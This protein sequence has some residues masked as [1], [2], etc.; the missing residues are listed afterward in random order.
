MSLITVTRLTNTLGH[1]P[2]LH[3]LGALQLVTETGLLSPGLWPLPAAE[4][5]EPHH[6]PGQLRQQLPLLDNLALQPLSGLTLL[7]N[8][9]LH[10]GH[11]CCL[12]SHL[13]QLLPEL[14]D[15]DEELPGDLVEGG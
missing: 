1:S 9:M 8:T 12:C 13:E 11:N 14:S 10:R 15:G 4:Y 5:L 2:R 6:L 7:D 3:N